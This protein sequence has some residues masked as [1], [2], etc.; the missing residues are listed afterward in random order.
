MTILNVI[1][2]RITR[3]ARVDI[4]G[5]GDTTPAGY[6]SV[7]SFDHPD[8]VYPGS[9]VIYHGVRDLLYKRS[10]ANP[11]NLAKYPFNIIDMNGIEIETN[12]PDT[13]IAAPEDSLQIDSRSVLV[14]DSEIIFS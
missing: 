11:A 8:P 7:G 14:G 5:E 3:V 6:V 2:N 12:F 13:W 10:H 4:D 1:Y 9:I